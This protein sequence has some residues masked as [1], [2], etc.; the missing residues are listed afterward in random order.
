MLLLS[1]SQ[2]RP[3]MIRSHVDWPENR[4]TSFLPEWDRSEGT[5]TTLIVNATDVDYGTL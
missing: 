1:M 3:M 4:D 5:K 2:R